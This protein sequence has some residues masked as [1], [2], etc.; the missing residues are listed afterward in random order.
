VSRLKNLL[1][2][3]V[4]CATC[5][6]PMLPGAAAFMNGQHFH[7]IECFDVGLSRWR[8]QIDA[9]LV[10]G[11]GSV[12]LTISIP[13]LSPAVARHLGELAGDLIR[14]RRAAARTIR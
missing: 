13:S 2:G 12:E 5:K 4:R 14:K 1:P 10:K 9:D 11:V 8:E 7:P 3:E 6:Q